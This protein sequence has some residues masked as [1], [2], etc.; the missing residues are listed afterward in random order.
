[1]TTSSEER[2][3]LE[4]ALANWKLGQASVAQVV[5]LAAEMGRQKFRE[6]IPTLT[7]FLENTEA[8][9]RYAAAVSLG[10]DLHYRPA[11]TKLLTLLR[12]DTDEDVRDAAI[13]ALQ[14]LWE[15]SKDPTVI[16]ALAQSSINDSDASTRAFAY[17]ALLVVNGI[18]VEERFELLGK[19]IPVDI[20]RIENILRE[21]AQ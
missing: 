21:T 8:T 6:G 10:I 4:H 2:G 11:T 14:A 7:E 5:R 12:E 9:V 18:S 20:S 13:A 16:R 17:K 3:S 19:Q 1:M 15:D